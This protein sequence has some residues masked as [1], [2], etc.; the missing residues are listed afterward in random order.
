M[1]KPSSSPAPA[2]HRDDADRPSDAG[3]L[4]P[5]DPPDWDELVESVEAPAPV[6]PTEADHDAA[7]AAIVA[8]NPEL[9]NPNRSRELV[10]A[11]KAQL[12]GPPRKPRVAELAELVAPVFP[13]EDHVAALHAAI[14][15][16]T[17][18]EEHSVLALGHAAFVA[19]IAR[20]EPVTEEPAA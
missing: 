11:V 5:I 1:T 4:A 13:T 20:G 6:F 2:P 15:A 19:S 17:P 7:R 16:L 14:P 18:D 3:E 10:R 9:E 12:A 8:A